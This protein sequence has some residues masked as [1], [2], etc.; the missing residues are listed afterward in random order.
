MPNLMCSPTEINT[1]RKINLGTTSLDLENQKAWDVL[2]E[3]YKDIFSLHQGDTGHT[4]IA[5]H[6]N[7]FRRSSSYDTK[8][9]ILC[10]K[11]IFNVSNMSWRC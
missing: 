11:N 9:F 6:E 1:H 5:Y 4:K 7:W 2:C 10:L 8:I 3:D